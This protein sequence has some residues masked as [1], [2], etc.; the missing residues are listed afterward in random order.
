MQAA[1]PH[2]TD[3]SGGLPPAALYGPHRSSAP[4]LR[5]R[6]LGPSAPR[7]AEQPDLAADPRLVRGVRRPERHHRPPGRVPLL[8]ASSRAVTGTSAPFQLTSA[9]GWASR[10]AVHAG[11]SARPK[12]EPTSSQLDASVPSGRQASGVRRVSPL[13]APR[14]V[15]TRPGSI[16]ELSST[17]PRVRR[18]TARS[19]AGTRRGAR[20]AK[21]R[22]E[23]T[24]R[25]SRTP[26]DA[27]RAIRP[28]A[29]R[30]RRGARR[31]PRA[32][33]AGAPARRAARRR[34]PA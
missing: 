6:R 17:L 32:P 21:A 3:H 15:R 25:T 31:R 26:G 1:A 12:L 19:T 20:R 13:R 11:W 14:A 22:V 34:T 8:P 5:A 27:P 10:L 16:R 4:C 9:S 28:P 33:A 23:E 24:F 29:P 18:C 30:P 7:D 2:R